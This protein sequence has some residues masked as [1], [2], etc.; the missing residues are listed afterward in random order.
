MNQ[1]KWQLLNFVLGEVKLAVY[2]SRKNKMEN[3]AGQEAASVW[4][5]NVRCRLR[6]EFSFYKMIN[7]LDSF[8]NILCHRNILCTVVKDELQFA[9]FLSE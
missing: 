1:K 6:L 5:C 4:C 7:D 3:R 2:V 9:H 8:K